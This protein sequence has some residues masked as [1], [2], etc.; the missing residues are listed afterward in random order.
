M[1]RCL[2][3]GVL[4]LALSA[5]ANT[6]PTAP[7]SAED[8]VTWSDTFP[9]GKVRGYFLAGGYVPDE[10]GGV[11]MKVNSIIAREIAMGF[12]SEVE[13]DV[14]FP[15]RPGAE[16]GILL[17]LRAGYDIDFTLVALRILNGKP[18]L[19][20]REIPVFSR[21]LDGPGIDLEGPWTLKIHVKHGVVWA[22]A[23]PKDKPEPT[24]WH[25]THYTGS[26][27]WEPRVVSFL[28]D[29]DQTARVTR[30]AVRGKKPVTRLY[31]EPNEPNAAAKKQVVKL[32]KKVNGLGAKGDLA[33]ALEPAREC[34][35]AS[36]KAFGPEHA[37][38]ATCVHNLAAALLAM[39]K[40]E[41]ALKMSEE[42][43]RL[44]RK[45]LPADHPQIALSLEARGAILVALGKIEDGA[46]QHREVLAFRRRVLGDNHPETAVSWNNLGEALALLMENEEALKCFQEALRIRQSLFGDSHRDVG[47]AHNNLGYQ[48][49]MMAEYQEARK[50]YDAA[51][52]VYR[53]VH[54]A[55]F[56]THPDTAKLENNLGVLFKA[57]GQFQEAND[58]LE[59][60]LNIFT[61]IGGAKYP[62]RGRVL[63]NMGLVAAES[64]DYVRARELLKEAWD[65][66]RESLGEYHHET[67]TVEM[68]LALLLEVL[69]DREAKK[70]IKESFQGLTRVL[71]ADHPTVA[72]AMQ[73]VVWLTSDITSADDIVRGPLERALALKQK[74]LGPTHPYTISSV[75]MLA[76]HLTLT[77]ESKAAE[78]L[79][80]A[81]LDAC[82]EKLG[83][84]NPLTL[85]TRHN[86][87]GV[88][89]A[90][91]EYVEATKNLRQSAERFAKLYGRSHPDTSRSLNIL[92]YSLAAQGKRAE[93]LAVAAEAASV[94]A[95][96]AGQLLAGSPESN[97]AALAEQW[98]P[99]V[100][101]YLSLA[102]IQP[103]RI[104]GHGPALFRTV[105]DWKATSG[106]ALLDR[107]ESIMVGQ[108]AQTADVYKSLL[109]QRRLL[110]QEVM[111]GPGPEGIE[112]YNK[113]LEDLRRE[114]DKRERVLG[115]EVR[116][117]A[118]LTQARQAGPAEVAQRLPAGGV[119][120]EFLL[121][122]EFKVKQGS[123]PQGIPA[124]ATY[125]ALLV[126]PKSGGGDPEVKLVPLGSTKEIDETIQKWRTQ[127]QKKKR[128]PVIEGQ[129]REKLW[130]PLAKALPIGTKRLFIAPAGQLALIP[131]EAIWHDNAFLVEKYLISYC[132][133]G[134]DL[135][136]RPTPTSPPGPPVLVADP[137]F[138]FLPPKN[139]E[140]PN[141]K[142]F[143]PGG[144][145]ALAYTSNPPEED[146]LAGFATE[147][148]AVEK[149]LKE[150][151][152]G[153]L[154]TLRGRE[155]TEENVQQVVQPRVLYFVTHG[156]FLKDQKTL[157]ALEGR[158]ITTPQTPTAGDASLLR[159]V[160]GED[161][162]LRSYL[163]LT[164]FNQWRKRAQQG[165][166]DGL[167]TARE[168]EM[169]NLWGTDLVVTAACKTGVGDVEV[170][171]GVIG[172]RRAFQQAGARTVVTSLWSVSDDKTAILLP[173]F[174]KL[175]LDGT[176]KAEALRKSQLEMIAALRESQKDKEKEYQAAPFAWAAFV[177]HGLPE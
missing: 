155:A 139:V 150:K 118:A 170:G 164:G 172:L 133:T 71:P 78:Q 168:V 115:K 44:R 60:A 152:P 123:L 79:L 12:E 16:R 6:D 116:G 156:N 38:T 83:E 129:L 88:Q 43:I 7:R 97:H 30:L 63:A 46:K 105:M 29:T 33:G 11:T 76:Q 45:A 108:V 85:L 124:E 24:V 98:R 157:V 54:G 109:V 136:P 131:F 144:V 121:L 111:R 173:R 135:I 147:A 61:R 106:R 91:G 149:L 166:S 18:V 145:S 95:T 140:V 171:E 5:L 125:L 163:C 72:Q 113:R 162:R 132:S 34:V 117:Y 4:F 37:F 154:K 99:E 57:M 19:E 42:A 14:A 48:F 142:Q 102:A 25:I 87:G 52:K 146:R 40:Y 159:Q 107:L 65:V 138:D 35:E 82:L 20:V 73:N 80:T 110:V 89:F 130:E 161:P 103:D 49:Y 15:K 81:S 2:C 55:R 17:T 169:L 176:P 70:L 104:E 158:P 160:Y 23:W 114:I 93:A 67:L 3:L 94:Y 86:L 122:D 69:G 27:G 39:G 151:F 56:A 50:Q 148:D 64:G 51:M 92:A 66:L 165:E 21:S 120:I 77:G 1:R 84:D 141:V 119:L 137:D 167:L 13:L 59:T 10:R 58:H 127:V 128:D 143:Q 68:N 112:K 62:L 90:R 174:L 41:D 100:R 32:A 74:R 101:L 177:C 175:Y 47:L 134:R 96:V 36:K 26:S 53:T 126:V 153:Q 28:P 22:K 9:D 75:N 8:D 31:L